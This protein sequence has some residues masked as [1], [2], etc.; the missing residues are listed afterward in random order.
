MGAHLS[1]AQHSKLSQVSKLSP[2][3][4]KKNVFYCFCKFFIVF[5]G[6]FID[7]NCTQGSFPCVSHNLGIVFFCRDKIL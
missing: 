1:P 3:K 7:F 2:P 5:Y 6:L 4:T